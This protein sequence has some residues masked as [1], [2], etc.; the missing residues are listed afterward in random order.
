MLRGVYAYYRFVDLLPANWV[1]VVICIVLRMTEGIGS[2]M[3]ITA[4][5]TVAPL[6]FP[7]SVATIVVLYTKRG[8]QAR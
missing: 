5:F 3:F 2:A 6:L 4:A 1:F 7:N 8:G